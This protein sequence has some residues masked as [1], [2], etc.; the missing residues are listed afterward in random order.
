MFLSKKK[1]SNTIL[2][3]ISFIH[4]RLVRLQTQVLRMTNK[5]QNLVLKLVHCQKVL[6]NKE[7]LVP[8]NPQLVLF[9][10]GFSSIHNY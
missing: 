6:T 1:R 7:S 8:I 10:T 5:I 9:L 4:V 3:H 2:H